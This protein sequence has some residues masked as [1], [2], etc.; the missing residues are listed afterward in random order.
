MFKA[1][2]REMFRNSNELTCM[3][4]SD[5]VQNTDKLTLQHTQ[6][7]T[8]LSFQNVIILLNVRLEYIMKPQAPWPR[9]FWDKE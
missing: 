5:N 7:V 1:E 9:P 6:R 3:H 2:A 4:T 8:S